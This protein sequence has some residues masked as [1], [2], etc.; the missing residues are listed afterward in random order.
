MCCTRLRKRVDKGENKKKYRD[1]GIMDSLGEE[2]MMG[3][4][5]GYFCDERDPMVENLMKL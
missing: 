1:A 3:G 4:G 5:F 2:C